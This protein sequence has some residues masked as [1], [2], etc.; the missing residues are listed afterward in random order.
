MSVTL[1]QGD[2]LEKLKELPDAS[3][4]LVL[5]DP[6][7]GTTQCKWDTVVSFDEMWSQVNR[8]C[9]KRAAQ[10]M[11][12][13]MPFS[14]AL[15]MSNPKNFRYEWIWEKPNATGFLNANRMP[16]KAHEQILVFYGALPTFNPQF[17]IGKKY[18]VSNGRK[19]SVYGDYHTVKTQNSGKRFPKDV[20]RVHRAACT[21]KRYHPT[22]KPVELLRYMIRTYSDPGCVVLDCFMGSGSTGV[23]C[24]QEG[25]DFIGIEKDP[26]CFEIAQ[27]RLEECQSQ[28][29]LE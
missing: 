1:M 3:V 25:R 29:R 11:F 18:S 2:C 15:C 6:P 8:V 20:L 21:G 16:M 13:Q 10:L 12:G 23:A 28:T 27:Q 24:I 7:Y 4:D 19:S 14:A 17:A 22:Q 9:K 26:G 5:T